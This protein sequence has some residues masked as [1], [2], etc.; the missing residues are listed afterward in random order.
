MK[1]KHA[2]KILGRNAAHRK[3]LLQNLTSQL[4]QYGS[5]VTTEAKAKELRRFFEPLVTKAKQELTLHNRRQLLAIID[6]TDLT[7][8]KEVSTKLKTRPGGYVR[9]S[10]LPITRNDAAQ[11][12]RV[13]IVE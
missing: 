9:L 3:Q 10:K 5:I 13:D 12:V 2:N 8:L 7:R 11:E 6:D 1:H 4:L